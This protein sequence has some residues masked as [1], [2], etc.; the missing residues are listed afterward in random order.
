MAAAACVVGGQEVKV[1][2]GTVF[3]R[4]QRLFNKRI[5]HD[6]VGWLVSMEARR[7]NKKVEPPPTSDL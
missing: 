4:W 5:I 1:Q 3:V 2:A 6:S 7:H